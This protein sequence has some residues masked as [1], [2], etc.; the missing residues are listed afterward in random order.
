MWKLRLRMLKGVWVHFLMILWIHPRVHLTDAP[1][2]A[3]CLAWR[4]GQGTVVLALRDSYSSTH[5]TPS[6]RCS[7]MVVLGF[8]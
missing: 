5:R 1:C 4:A 6:P 3:A 2:H 8:Q 7:C